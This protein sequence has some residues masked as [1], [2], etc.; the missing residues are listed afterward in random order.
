MM[1]NN[2]GLILAIVANE[3]IGVTDTANELN[4]LV[5]AEDHDEHKELVTG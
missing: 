3:A 1:D 2:L 4:E 5:V